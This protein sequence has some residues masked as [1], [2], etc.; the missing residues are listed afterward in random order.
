MHFILPLATLKTKQKNVLN[1]TQENDAG[2]FSRK[3]HAADSYICTLRTQT[4]LH[5]SISAVRNAGRGS[6]LAVGYFPI[7]PQT[8]KSFFNLFAFALPASLY[9]Y[10]IYVYNHISC[11]CV[12]RGVLRWWMKVVTAW[13]KQAQNWMSSYEKPRNKFSSL[14]MRYECTWYKCISACMYVCVSAN[15]LC[16]SVVPVSASASVVRET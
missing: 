8:T 16:R 3:C 14:E 6:P 1:N 11:E 9:L 15:A 7:P 13:E 12:G 10:N 5:V 2:V 4:S